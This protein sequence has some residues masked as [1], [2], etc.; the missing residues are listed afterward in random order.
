MTFGDTLQTFLTHLGYNKSL[1]ILDDLRLNKQ[2]MEAKQILMILSGES[3]GYLHHPAVTQWRGFEI[4]L[5]NYGAAACYQ[6]RIVRKNSCSLYPWFSA[7]AKLLQDQGYSI[8]L[9]MWL[10]DLDYLRSHRS[11]LVR[12]SHPYYGKL[13]PGMADNWP[14]LW[15]MNTTPGKYMLRVSNADQAR[16]RS[17]ERQLPDYL[18]MDPVSGEVKRK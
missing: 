9:P 6:W 5:A 3:E 11:N 13:F 12:K 4:A 10:K 17:G 7:R 14:Y 15:P 18:Q 16:L 8:D 2:R 1:Q